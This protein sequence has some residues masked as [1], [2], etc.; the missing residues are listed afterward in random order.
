[1]G[2]VNRLSLILTIDLE[3]K[4]TVI[5]IFTIGSCPKPTVKMLLRK[6]FLLL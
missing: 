6:C 4:E 5:I 1:M 3:N 2:N